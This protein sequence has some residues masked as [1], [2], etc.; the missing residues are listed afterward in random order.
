VAWSRTFSGR[1]AVDAAGNVAITGGLRGSLDFGNGPLT[2]AGGEDVF[3]ALLDSAGNHRFS[4]VFGDAGPTQR[5]EAV[6]FDR[7]GHILVSGVLDGA[8]DFGLGELAPR[9]GACPSEVG[10]KLAGF[11]AKFDGAGNAVFS[12]SKGPMRTLSGIAGNSSGQVLVSGATPGG[13][14]PY[15]IPLLL[16]LDPNGAEL[17]RETEWP[18]SGIGS[19]RALSVD[20]CDS[21]IWSLTARPDLS[22]DEAPY[23]AK[24]SPN[25]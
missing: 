19:G 6:A 16:A 1:I 2:S 5:G 25:L 7:G 14:S 23:L 4:R 11:V 12:V 15:R 9:A 8:V 10:C 18:E 24:I 3:V 20:A 22:S 21:V 17:W 13:V